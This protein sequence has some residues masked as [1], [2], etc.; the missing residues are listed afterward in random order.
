M[1]ANY[2]PHSLVLLDAV[3]LQSIKLYDVKDSSGTTSRVSAV[4]TAPPR[5]S[6][7]AALKDIPEVWEISYEDN[8]PVGFDGWVHD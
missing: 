4:Y 5:N 3:D 2:L 6:F 7:I 1:V 8:P